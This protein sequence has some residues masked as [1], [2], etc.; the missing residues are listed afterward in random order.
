METNRIEQQLEALPARPG[1]YLFKD[2][3]DNILYVGKAAS[4]HHRV[5]SYFSSSR[6]MPPKMLRMMGRVTDLD[7]YV[8][9]SE[10]EAI[11]LECNLIKKH[12]PHYNVRLKDDKTYPYLKLTVNEDWPRAYLTRRVA[13]DGARYFGPFAS[14]GSVHTTLAL[15]EKLFR[16]RSCRKAITG[17]EHRPCLEHHI[18]RCC[19]PCIG[20]VGR[21]EYRQA[22]DRVVLFL[23]GKQETILR[24]LRASMAQAAQNLEYEK[25]ALIRD[26][27]RA[28]EA[29]VER[30]KITLASGDTDVMAFAQAGELAFAL[31]FF[32]RQGRLVGREPFTL[33]GTR[34]E[35]PSRVMTSFVQ[36]F[37][38]TA[39]HIPRRILLQ[40]PIEGMPVIQ[41]WLEDKRGKKVELRVPRRGSWKEL[42]DMVAS[43][44]R[45]SMEQSRIKS[46]AEPDVLITALEELQEVLS[47]PS[48][49]QRLECYDIS[50]IQGTSAVGSMVVFEGGLPR[51]SHYRRFQI[52]T[53]AGADDYAMIQEVLRRR[54]KRAL[55]EDRGEN[56][57]A[58]LP[59]LVL[60]DGGKGQLNA[61]LKAMEAAGVGSIPSAS[62]AKEEETVFLPQLAEPIM[63]RRESPALRLLQR[64]RDEA[65]RFALGYYRK[66][67]RR[68]TFV[69]SLDGIPGVGA[70]RKRALLKRFGS[71]AAVKRATAE[72]LESV[73]GMTWSVARKVKECL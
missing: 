48:L 8:T 9:D 66:V 26:Q 69:S 62:I 35:A 1:V 31:V 57:W 40:H 72:E 23:E 71:V 70:K 51:K 63:L 41:K 50:N 64:A 37:Y 16:L 5:A 45:E 6:D 46:V 68:R 14:A 27:I 18:N 44:A 21:E 65:H 29:V 38:S 33:T 56:A 32:I 54:F 30:Q 19:G 42:V 20:A 28:V 34:D 60:I 55:T 12:C 24:G 11:L 17:N 7:Y 36:Q 53:V 22:V 3:S 2:T 73:E 43:N 10:Q 58:V 39:A 15:L 52:R 61:A 13:K 47:L 49:P 67:H 25:A 4:L 59:D